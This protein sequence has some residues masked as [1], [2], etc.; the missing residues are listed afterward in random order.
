MNASSPLS[1]RRW[2]AIDLMTAGGTGATFSLSRNRGAWWVDSPGG[3]GLSFFVSGGAGGR[4]ADRGIGLEHAVEDAG[5]D[6]NVIGIEQGVEDHH[7]AHGV[8]V[9][10]PA[11]AALV[12]NEA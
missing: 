3:P 9:M 7:L 5:I 11:I 10:C 4:S 12:G 8:A 6:R 1:V 2:F